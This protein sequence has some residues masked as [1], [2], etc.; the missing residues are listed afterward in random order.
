MW[1]FTSLHKI[2]KTLIIYQHH[3]IGLSEINNYSGENLLMYWRRFEVR[4]K[5]FE[6]DTSE[7]DE[8]KLK[9]YQRKTNDHKTYI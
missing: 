4:K 5:T 7:V 1:T 6:G 9:T 2:L 3:N 8:I